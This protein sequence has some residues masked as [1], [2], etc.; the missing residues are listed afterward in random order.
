M[1]DGIKTQLFIKS[2]NEIRIKKHPE[3]G[4]LFYLGIL[5]LLFPLNAKDS[6]F[7]LS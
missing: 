3:Y 1:P 2:V 6:A 7:Q 4:M 5:L